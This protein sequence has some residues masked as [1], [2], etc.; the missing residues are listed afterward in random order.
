MTKKNA[1][2]TKITLIKSPVGHIAVQKA[3]VKA[4]GLHKMNRSVVHADTPIIRGMIKTVFHLD[5]VEE[6]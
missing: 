4:L 1:N 3:T 5:R 6:V 2:Q